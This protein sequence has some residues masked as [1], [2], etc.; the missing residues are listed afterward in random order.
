MG[1][2]RGRCRRS[3][4]ERLL[5]ISDQAAYWR[6]VLSPARTIGPR[7]LVIEI[8]CLVSYAHKPVSIHPIRSRSLILTSMTAQTSAAACRASHSC[9]RRSPP[10]APSC[11]SV[12]R[13]APR[14]SP[15]MPLFSGTRLAAPAY[16]APAIRTQ[17]TSATAR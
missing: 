15:S 13:S 12:R 4:E 5:M 16:F 10:A 7:S 9:P 6:G 8:F 3:T 2:I 1:A 17:P 11:E 14:P